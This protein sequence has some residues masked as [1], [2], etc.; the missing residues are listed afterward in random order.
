MKIFISLKNVATKTRNGT[1]RMIKKLTTTLQIQ[2]S[3]WGVI[4]YL[5]FFFFRIYVDRPIV[6]GVEFSIERFLSLFKF[7]I[8]FILVIC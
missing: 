1:K 2:T 3:R 5:W 8:V 4:A 7:L 6:N